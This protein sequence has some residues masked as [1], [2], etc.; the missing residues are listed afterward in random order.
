[1]NVTIM[2]LSLANST[3]GTGNSKIQLKGTLRNMQ[4]RLKTLQQGYFIPVL[5]GQNI[6]GFGFLH[7]NSKNHPIY[8]SSETLKLFPYFNALNNQPYLFQTCTF[9]LK[10]VLLYIQCLAKVFGPLELCNLLPH[11]RLQT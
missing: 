10:S 2:S 11:F 8:V 7:G 1:M 6:S 4:I 5:E 3:G 9:I